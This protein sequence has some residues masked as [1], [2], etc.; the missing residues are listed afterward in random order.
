MGLLAIILGVLLLLYVL[1]DA[2]E[3][4]VLPR[5]VSR[6]FRLTRFFYV[7]TWSPWRALAR[8]RREGNPRENFLSIYGP[9]SLLVLL[10]TWAA[11]LIVGFA[12]IHWGAGSRLSLPEGIRR[13]FVADL[14]FSGTT[15]FTLGLGD[16][17]P[18]ST[19]E[20][21]LT[22]VE[23]GTGFGL[24]ALVISY[25]PVLSQG[26]SRRESA[27]TL[28]DARAGSP[29]TAFELLRRESGD[30][31][32]E[33]LAELFKDWERWSAELLESHVS[34]P[35]LAYYRSQHDNQSWV[36]AL[37][38]ILDACVLTIAGIP[39]GPI[40]AARLT[41]AM[42]RHTVVDMCNVFHLDS[43]PLHADRLPAEEL[44]RLHA[45]LKAA[46]LALCSVGQ[47]VDKLSHL[48]RM[49]EPYVNALSKHLLMPL[50]TWLP[51]EGAKDN[52]QTT[53]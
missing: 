27:I 22:I 21:V 35:V 9:L 23:A 48:R 19:S 17:S 41:F 51:P 3:T 37:T 49:Y 6:R 10:G 44:E 32:P 33:S 31:S 40:R 13:G 5:R 39:K 20:R 4:V 28:L 12:L 2:F 53:A 34:F 45:T 30:H 29:P 50:P 8:R 25:L 43:S 1:R 38:T 42:A 52:W 26:F 24:L 46:G 47:M 16:V 14:Y 18:S 15:L 11:A 36:A 7:L